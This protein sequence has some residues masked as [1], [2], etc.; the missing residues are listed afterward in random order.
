[1]AIQLIL[2]TSIRGETDVL[3]YFSCEDIF[4]KMPSQHFE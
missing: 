1:M 3:A 2:M 4:Q